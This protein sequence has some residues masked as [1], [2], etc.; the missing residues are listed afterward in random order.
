MVVY[1]KFSVKLESMLNNSSQIQVLQS[2]KIDPILNA[3]LLH[4]ECTCID[5]VAGVQQV[6]SV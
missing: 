1:T 4:Q 5:G 6:P 2:A 3:K